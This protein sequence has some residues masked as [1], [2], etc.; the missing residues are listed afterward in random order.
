MKPLKTRAKLSI[1]H[2]QPQS[3]PGRLSPR[4]QVALSHLGPAEV[5]RL[6][7]ESTFQQYALLLVGLRRN[8]QFY[9]L[10][11]PQ[12]GGSLGLALTG[13]LT[14]VPRVPIGS[15]REAPRWRQWEPA[16]PAPGVRGL[17]RRQPANTASPVSREGVR[18][19]AAPIAAALDW[20]PSRAHDRR[21]GT[22]SCWCPPG[23]QPWTSS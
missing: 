11:E 10:R 14:R 4:T 9:W 22:D 19:P 16:A 5:R 2:L 1:T 23:S 20:C 7:A 21:C 8:S 6:H 15:T 18:E 13:R 3:T 12:G 17:W